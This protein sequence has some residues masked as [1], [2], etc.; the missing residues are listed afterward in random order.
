MS[1]HN[2]KLI[3]KEAIVR[4]GRLQQLKRPIPRVPLLQRRLT[5]SKPD[6]PLPKPLWLLA[7]SWMFM[8]ICGVASAI[9]FAAIC[10]PT[11]WLTITAVNGDMENAAIVFVLAFSGLAGLAAF[12]FLFAMSLRLPA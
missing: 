12:I 7:T 3:Q 1:Q 8:M 6:R 9:A 10:I 4:L 2:I 11:G 5:W